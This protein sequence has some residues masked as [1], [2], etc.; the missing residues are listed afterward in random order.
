M[1]ERLVGYLDTTRQREL[2]NVRAAAER[3]WKTPLH[4]YY[5]D[6][7]VSHSERAIALLDGL[8]AGV[9]NTDK[10]LSPG[11]V[12]V[13]LAAAYL[14]DIGMQNERFAS[15]NV[16]EI[17]RQ[18]H[19]QTAE[20]IYRVWEDPANAVNLALGD[21]PALVEA[22]ALV[23]QAHRKVDLSSAEYDPLPHGGETLRLRLLAALLRFAD[24]LDIDYRRVDLEAM[25]LMNLPVESQLH[26]WKCYYVNGVSIE[27][28]YIKIAYRLPQGRPDYEQLIVPLVEKDV[29][30]RMADLEEIFR[31]HAVK[32]AVG[33]SSV[34][35]MRLVQPLPE[36]V[37]QLA[38]EM[39]AGKQGTVRPGDELPASDRSSASP[40]DSATVAH[41]HIVSAQR[42]QHVQNQT[43]VSGSAYTIHIN[44]AEGLAIGNGAQVIQ[45]AML[46]VGSPA[47]APGVDTAALHARLQRLDDVQLDT[48]C[49]VHFP[50][51][52]DRFGRGLRR[53]EKVNLLL[54]HC[55]HNPEDAARLATLLGMPAATPASITPS[56]T[57]ETRSDARRQAAIPPPTEIRH[58]YALLIGVSEYVN[59][60]RSLPHTVEDVIALESLLRGAGYTVR[61]LHSHQTASDLR[62]TAANIWESLENMGGQTGPGDLLLVYFGGHGVLEGDAAYLIP[63][64]GGKSSL[65]RTAI[66]LDEFKTTIARSGAQAKV[67]VLD[68]CHS[69]IGRDEQG[70]DD[71]FERRVHREATGTATLAACRLGEVAYE[72]TE[73]KNGAFTHYLLQGL[74]GAAASGG[75]R[76]VT[77]DSLKNYV[78]NEVKKWGI[79]HN[80][81]QW[82]NASTQLVGDPLLIDLSHI[83]K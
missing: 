18:H 55:R 40:A 45:Q 48:L 50:A 2:V 29:R 49:L 51:V 6:H 42:D 10:R 63:A 47:A 57:P 81:H 59:A 72:H 14:H 56:A 17:R 22:V 61:A 24:E 37:E 28:E 67:I 78:T 75:T 21:D 23:A 70:M 7:T 74:R 53:D 80:R 65:R 8:T 16:E 39:V 27:D 36:A 44:H 34:R 13:L 43:N 60:Y 31:A 35:L 11:E 62:P 73:S 20:M 15:G 82:P 30:V 71:E 79:A 66:D 32:V 9:M 68:A 54:D 25:K 41:A 77:L 3:I 12:F 76:L 19:E 4:R 46:L 38:R 52:Y 64:D 5:T 58:Y 33:K 1:C 83:S 26:W 69:G